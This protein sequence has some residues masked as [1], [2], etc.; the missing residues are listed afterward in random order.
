MHKIYFDNRCIVICEPQ[1]EALADSNAVV[2]LPGD[3]LDIGTFARMFEVTKSLSKIYIP[4]GDTNETY[5]SFCAEFKEV[6]A[7][8]GLA[9]NKRGD[10]L[11]IKRN[12]MWDLPKGHQ[13]AGEDIS[14]TA[15]REVEE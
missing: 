9:V 13:E 7:A 1:D 3:H 12:N 15:L 11:L 4:S 2:F 8:G 6:N 14:F 10:F 5:K